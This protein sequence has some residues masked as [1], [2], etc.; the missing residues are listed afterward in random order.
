MHTTRRLILIAAAVPLVMPANS[1]ANEGPVRLVVSSP[2]GDSADVLARLLAEHLGH[3]LK[4][5]VIVDNS[6]GAGGI[7][8]AQYLKNASPDGNTMLLA[9]S[10]LF[11][12]FPHTYK[13]LP[14]DPVRDFQPVAIAAH[15]NL[16]IAVEADRGP[17]AMSEF[18][19][20]LPR[21]PALQNFGTAAAGS[22]NHFLGLR[23]GE[24]TGVP[25]THVA[26]RGTAPAKHALLS[27]EVGF[28]VGPIAS[29]WDQISAGRVRVL[30]TS[31]KDRDPLL[32]TVP[33]LRESGV[34]LEGD[35]WQAIY[36]PAGT[37]A[38]HVARLTQAAMSA[39][40]MPVLSRRMG[41]LGFNV[42]P[43]GPAKVIDAMQ[44]NSRQ[45]LPV[46]QKSGFQSE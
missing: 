39:L 12:I 22:L 42:A 32:P 45:W 24:L 23:L 18:L 16:A 41:E 27:G 36:V 13:N 44:A 33:T 17:S 21:E 25:L 26:Y 3:Q 1:H 37:P 29:L 28:V 7:V 20:R 5:P 34:A 30:A 31:G 9:P 46:I 19:R 40:A 11:V 15:M 14:Y 6:A 35:V 38:D 43:G 8:A 4:R 10:G 2:P